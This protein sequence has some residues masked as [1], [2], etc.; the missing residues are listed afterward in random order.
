[1][2]NPALPDFRPQTKDSKRGVMTRTGH[3]IAFAF[4]GGGSL[5]AIQVGM[6]RV[7]LSAGVQPDFVVGASVGAMNAAYFAGAPNAEGVTRLAEIWFRLRRREVFPVTFKSAF[8]LL[9]HP[10]GVIDSG[11]LRHLIETNLAYVRLEDATVPVHV[12]ATDVEGMAVVLSKGPA[13]DAILAST[14]IPGI[15][16][17]VRID[18]QPLI[19]GAV[20]RNSP[21]RVA[22]DLGAS[23]I[24]VLPTGY[25]CALDEPPKGGDDM[26]L[27]RSHPVDR[28]APHTRCRAAHG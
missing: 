10:A 24:V 7:L 8:G 25:A 12:I 17:P 27:A 16:P 11:G 6:L 15:F 28:V 22:A 4:A 5:G 13:I 3:K 20:A 18:G 1:M 2:T 9:R 26:G 19:D 23:R 14:A 21:I